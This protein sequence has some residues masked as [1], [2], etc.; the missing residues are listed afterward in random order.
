MRESQKTYS[1]SKT[2]LTTHPRG[3]FNEYDHNTLI[4]D[5]D[6]LQH[7]IDIKRVN[8]ST[9]QTIMKFDVDKEI[10]DLFFDRNAKCI[11]MDDG[12]F[13]SLERID[14]NV[15]AIADK[16]CRVQVINATQRV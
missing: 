13:K 11:G 7:I 14:F 1:T 16:I 8:L 5:E 2:V 3:V 15:N 6:P 4:F 12:S 9:L 10:V